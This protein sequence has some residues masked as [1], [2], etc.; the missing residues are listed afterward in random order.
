MSDRKTSNIS[1]QVV[2]SMVSAISTIQIHIVDVKAYQG[3]A[4]TNYKK[5]RPGMSKVLPDKAN[6]LFIIFH[7]EYQEEQ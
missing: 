2:F 6:L 7:L 1:Q 4:T 5:F 3:R